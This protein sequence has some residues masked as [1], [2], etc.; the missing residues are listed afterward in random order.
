M[1]YDPTADLRTQITTSLASSFRHLR[2]LPDVESESDTYIDCLLLHS[3][4]RTVEET[5]Q[6]WGILEEF[7]PSR[8]RSLGISNVSLPV[9]Q[10]IVT[11][12]KVKPTMV[13][14]RFYPE[15]RYDVPLRKF[16]QENGIVYQSFWTLTGNPKLLRCPAVID[17]TKAV[18]VSKEIALYSLVM[19]LDIAVLNGTTSKGNMEAD[20]EGVALVQKWR[21]ENAKNWNELI[22]DFEATLSA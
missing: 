21:D 8:I 13:Q 20:L 3:P 15:T 10:A 16:C 17:L 22:R 4:L 1:P 12:A 5:I 2:P 11:A 6:G 7:V 9:L 18:G 19:G 14:N